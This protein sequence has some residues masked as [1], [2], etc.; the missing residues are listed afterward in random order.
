MVFIV[1]D[2]ELPYMEDYKQLLPQ[3]WTISPV[4]VV[5]YKEAALYP[6]A[7]E[8]YTYFTLHQEVI[9]HRYGT[10]TYVNMALDVPYK[11]AGKN[12]LKVKQLGLVD[13]YPEIGSMGIQNTKTIIEQMY[14]QYN[15]RNFS[16]PYM[17]AYL[18]FTQEQIETGSK[19]NLADPLADK[20]LLAQLKKSTLYVPDSLIYH[21]N[22]YAGGKEKRQSEDLFSEYKGKFQF[23]ATADLIKLLKEKKNEPLFLFEYVQNSNTKLIRVLELR[24]LSTAFRFKSALSYNLKP[25]DMKLILR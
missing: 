23:I 19:L 8:H 25:K 15:I 16:L 21:R 24:T 3:V 17:L 2:K 12:R 14:T 13:M 10:N 18:K 4:K 6:A 5:T 22:I 7:S 1:P 20:V 9:T 11:E